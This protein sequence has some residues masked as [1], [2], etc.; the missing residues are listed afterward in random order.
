MTYKDWDTQ[1]AQ[2]PTTRPAIAA[3][4]VL[5]D[6]KAE[7]DALKARVKK[8]EAYRDDLIRRM[9]DALA[10]RD[11]WGTKAAEYH[12]NWK[13]LE[14]ELRKLSTECNGIAAAALP[15]EEKI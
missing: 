13:R 7:R 8:L 4:L 9:A 14:D 2:H 15:H 11:V 12:H 5:A 10:A 3:R 6:W 1:T